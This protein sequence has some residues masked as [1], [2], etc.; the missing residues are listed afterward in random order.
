MEYTNSQ[1]MGIIGEWIHSERDREVLCY[2]FIDGLTIDQ[3]CTRYQAKHPEYYLSCDT[4]KRIIRKN[5]N[6]IFNH[7]PG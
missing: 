4:I 3:I 6:L 7:L 5:E 1:I 2:K